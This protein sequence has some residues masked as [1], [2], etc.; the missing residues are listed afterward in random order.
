MSKQLILC[1]KPSVA[2]D[3]AKGLGNNFKKKDGYL[4]NDKYIITWAYG[5][6]CELKDPED[7]NPELKVWKMDTLPIFPE[8]FE[9]K[10]NKE[11]AKQF[12]VIK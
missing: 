11:G 8:K 1:E 12:K 4:E 10:V 5:H 9:Y 7:Y 6:L 2:M 3:F